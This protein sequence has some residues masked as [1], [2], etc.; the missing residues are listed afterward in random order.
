MID[1]YLLFDK[2]YSLAFKPH[3]LSTT[4]FLTSWLVRCTIGKQTNDA[5][6]ASMLT[7]V[8]L[9]R[10]YCDYTLFT[11]CCCSRLH[12]LAKLLYWLPIPSSKKR[13]TSNSCPEKTTV[14]SAIMIALSFWFTSLSSMFGKSKSIEKFCS[15]YGTY[16]TSRLQYA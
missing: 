7:A 5:N 13:S 12:S 11:I 9:V 3:T 6:V 8:I 2:V 4:C 16:L 1:R 10:F 14:I 15:D